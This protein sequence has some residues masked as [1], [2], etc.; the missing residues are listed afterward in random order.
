MENEE[1]FCPNCGAEISEKDLKC[2]KCGAELSDEQSEDE[3][4]TVKLKTFL[5]EIDA[6]IA[7]SVLDDEGIESFI[8]KD[9]E[10]SMNPSLQF[11]LG[12]RL[13]VLENDAEKAGKILEQLK[14]TNED[15]IIPEDE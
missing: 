2:G 8:I 3:L 7:K 10:G 6:Q 14:D 15:L 1:Y 11:T 5:N 9:D 4:H 13:Y 12:V